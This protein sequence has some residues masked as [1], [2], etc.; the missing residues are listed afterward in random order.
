MP[1]PDRTARL[2][3]AVQRLVGTLLGVIIAWGLLSLQLPPV[4]AIL[5]AVGL[6]ACT[7][8]FVGRNYGL[9][10]LFITPLALSMTQLAHPLPIG[11]LI[12]DRALE[13]VLGVAVAVVITVLTRERRQDPDAD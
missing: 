9:A 11:E 4:V 10:L 12:R 1:A 6:H 13:T 7:E 8:L 2:L 3:R 5:V